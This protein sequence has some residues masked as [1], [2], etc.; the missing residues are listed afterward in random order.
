MIFVR[1]NRYLT[2][3]YI[4]SFVTHDVL[5]LWSLKGAHFKNN[6]TMPEWTIYIMNYFITWKKVHREIYRQHLRIINPWRMWWGRI[7]ICHRAINNLWQIIGKD[8]KT[9]I[10]TFT[11]L[12][13]LLWHGKI[14]TTISWLSV[15]VIVSC[16]P[17]GVV[18]RDIWRIWIQ[19]ICIIWVFSGLVILFLD[20]TYFFRNKV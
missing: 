3:S 9:H 7:W 10:S 6:T 5:P 19:N 13:T 8:K 1:W 17:D 11:A 15:H 14:I 16:L 18:G 12:L 20:S 4:R 2:N